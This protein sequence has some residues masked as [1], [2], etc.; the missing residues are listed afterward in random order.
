MDS[1]RP[2]A[3]ALPFGAFDTV[4]LYAF[5]ATAPL[6]P[7]VLA[8]WERIVGIGSDDPGI[9]DS[10]APYLHAFCLSVMFIA[11]GYL[12]VCLLKTEYARINR[13][14]LMGA[15]LSYGCGIALLC[16]WS[17]GALSGFA[18]ETAAGLL[19]G[20]GTAIMA[21]AWFTL[22]RV[23]AFRK[24]LV[25]TIGL[26]IG[27]GLATVCLTLLDPTVARIV[28]AGASALAIAGCLHAS[29][30]KG[31]AIER[32]R[33]QD[34]NWWDVFGHMDASL[35][36]GNTLKSPLSRIL[37]FIVAPLAML[38]LFDAVCGVKPGVRTNADAGA[39]ACAFLG[40]VA[41]IPLA[42]FKS[43]RALFTFAYRFFMPVVAFAA[44]TMGAFADPSVSRAWIVNGAVAYCAVY[45]VLIGTIL[46]VPAGRMQSLALPSGSL[47]LVMLCLTDMLVN[48]PLHIDNAAQSLYPSVVVLMVGT[49]VLFAV[50]PGQRLWRQVLAGI[51]SVKAANPP[52]DF[53]EQRCKAIAESYR[54]TPRETEL[55]ALLGRGRTAARVA[56]E[57]V[58][59]ESTIRTHRKNIY[60]KMGIS[61]REELMDLI[62]GAE[63]GK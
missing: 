57:L 11:L 44:L 59:A 15:A 34:S 53:Y 29:I 42:L 7:P 17:A 61:L 55:L 28:L 48:A 40:L 30:Q 31:P 24:A 33:K 38:L 46:V 14:L 54:L 51:D 32:D 50:V 27:I 36:D 18:G 49:V 45:A 52:S 10:S 1:H 25:T 3:R 21:L 12:F 16:A 20:F 63:L 26:C 35:I 62:E 56:Q 43:D 39:A 23:S 9:L 60:Q 19:T 58:V 8:T 5:A 41:L 47:V 13:P 22:L 37:F 2:H 4:A 6:T